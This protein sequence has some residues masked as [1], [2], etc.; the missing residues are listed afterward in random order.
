MPAWLTALIG[1][2]LGT[3]Q[4]VFV[5]WVRDRRKH[6]R[7]LRFL[8]AELRRLRSYD[9]R[10]EWDKRGAPKDIYLPTAPRP[11]PQFI[12]R[13]AGVDFRITDEAAD[14]NTQQMLI[15]IASYC[16]SVEHYLDQITRALER[17][18][19]D[20]RSYAMKVSRDYDKGIET[21]LRGVDEAE[22]DLNRRL[23]EVRGWRQL[24]RLL[25]GSVKR[26]PKP[27]G[28]SAHGREG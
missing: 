12:E 11:V 19:D 2:A 26:P 18:G 10:F 25:T 4:I 7:D 27:A 9:H 21:F 5:D 6:A 3:G 1:Y 22:R 16:A 15:S 28:A 14:D 23:D 8:R 13:V 17:G 24:T 20:W